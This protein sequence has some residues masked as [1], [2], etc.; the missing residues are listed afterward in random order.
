M[1]IIV[2]LPEDTTDGFPGTGEVEMVLDTMGA[3]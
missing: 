1:R 2:P 3:P